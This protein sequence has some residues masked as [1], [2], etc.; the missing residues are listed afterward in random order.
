[1]IVGVRRLGRAFR[2][3]NDSEGGTK[4]VERSGGDGILGSESRCSKS[5]GDKPSGIEGGA[6]R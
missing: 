3:V 6:M 2:K 4:A 5:P 1:M